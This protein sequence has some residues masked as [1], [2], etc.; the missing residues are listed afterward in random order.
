MVQS[1]RRR[2]SLRPAHGGENQ[3]NRNTRHSTLDAWE[4][5][6]FPANLKALLTPIFGRNQFTAKG[7]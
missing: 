4:G 5:S 7:P 6:K 3:N 2:P 1:E